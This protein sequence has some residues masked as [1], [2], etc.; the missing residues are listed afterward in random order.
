M[1]GT[2]VTTGMWDDNF[3]GNPARIAHNPWFKL[4]LID[5]PMV[6][7]TIPTIAAVP[8]ILSGISNPLAAI[9]AQA[10]S[11]L[12]MRIQTAFPSVFIPARNGRIWALHFGITSSTEISG[13][14]RES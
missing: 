2:F 6:E 4:R 9:G 11:P 7:T 8:A 13:I 10:G 5:V 3:Y 1:G 14:L 12:Q